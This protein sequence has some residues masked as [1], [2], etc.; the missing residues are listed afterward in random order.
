MAKRIWI[1]LYL[2][3]LDDPRKARLP[4][5]LWRRLVECSL[6]AGLQ[7]DDGAL[8][9]VEEMAWRL[10]LPTDR[11]LEDLHGLAEAGMVQADGTD[12]DAPGHWNVPDFAK[13][14]EPLSSAER[15]RHFRE[16]N[17]DV[18]NRY[19]KCN[20]EVTGDSSS[21]STSTSFS[22]SDSDSEQRIASKTEAGAGAET[23][24]PGPE[25]QEPPEPRSPLEALQHPDLRVFADVTGGRIP[26][27]AQYASVIEAVRFLR[28]R[29]GLDEAGLAAYLAPF[30]LAWSGRK[31]RDGRPYDPANLTWLTEWA[32]N[33]SLPVPG[34][35]PGGSGTGGSSTPSP[36]ETRRMLDERDRVIAQAVPPPES[37]RARMR[38]LKEKLD[39]G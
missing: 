34:P 7:G 37:V 23:G 12:A 15:V 13:E 4:T 14:Q 39:A 20:A 19:K 3:M 28:K 27:A 16:R 8:P 17:A 26:G 36:Q 33:G 30:W 32:L 35:A 9:P 18:T 21:T 25:A 5:H 1:K 22:D 11:L 6:L 24:P 2:E 10:H 38:L 31:R 29:K